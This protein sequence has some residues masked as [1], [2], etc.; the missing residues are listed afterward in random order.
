MYVRISTV[1]GA[2]DIDGLA[3]HVRDVVLPQVREQRGF[4][5]LTVSADRTAAT[6]AV[7]TEW[8]S[9]EALRASAGMAAEAR[10]R[11]LPVTGGEVSV[12]VLEQVAGAVRE[13]AAPGCALRVRQVRVTPESAED[14]IAFFAT[15]VVPGMQ[16]APGFRAVR[17]L[18]DRATGEGYIGVVFS[19]EA[20]LRAADAGFEKGR[21]LARTTRGVD[22]GETSVREVLLVASAER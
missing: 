3:A 1:R 11:A 14:N 4:R 19:D 20:A 21:A 2:K 22:F 7:L 12:E 10:Q 5:G 15:Q 16:A 17:Y 8:D 9:E 13:P 6:A 18:I